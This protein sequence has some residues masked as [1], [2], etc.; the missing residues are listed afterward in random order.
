MGG[1]SKTVAEKLQH[2]DTQAGTSR[3]QPELHSTPTA[4]NGFFLPCSEKTAQ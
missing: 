4:V 3:V 2:E 1:P